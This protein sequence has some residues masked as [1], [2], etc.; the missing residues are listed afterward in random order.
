MW[1][2]NATQEMWANIAGFRAA[3]EGKAPPGM[4]AVVEVTLES[5]PTFRPGVTQFQGDGWIAFETIDPKTGEVEVLLV[6]GD[7]LREIRCRFVP[8][9]VPAK[10]KVPVGF[11]IGDIAGAHTGA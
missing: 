6:P 10:A 1:T 2:V 3:M 5:G 7:Q 4:E 9:S 8:S 11:A